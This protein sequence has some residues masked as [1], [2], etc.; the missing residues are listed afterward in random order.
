MKKQAIMI[1]SALV[2]ATL[3]VAGNASAQRQT[4]W[5]KQNPH[6]PF[7]TVRTPVAGYSPTLASPQPETM[8]TLTPDANR[9]IRWQGWL[10]V[11]TF[12][13]S[14][15]NQMQ[16][17]LGR[18]I[19][20]GRFTIAEPGILEAVKN[21]KANNPFFRLNPL[22][23]EEGA[24]FIGTPTL[25]VWTY[26]HNFTDTGLYQLYVSAKG[27][28]EIG[29]GPGPGP[30]PGHGNPI[31]HK[32]IQS[33]NY[34]FGGDGWRP[35]K[36]GLPP[37][38]HPIIIDVEVW[39]GAVARVNARGELEVVG[40]E[41]GVIPL[42]DGTVERI[43]M[44][45]WELAPSLIS[46]PNYNP[47]RATGA[48]FVEPLERAITIRENLNQLQAGDVQQRVRTVTPFQNR[49]VPQSRPRFS[50]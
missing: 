12:S 38:W 5:A 46:N 42:G 24:M 29:D 28:M 48:A 41:A 26:R 23:E 6:P 32:D 43:P 11:D 49:V 25:Y 35:G 50:R 45:D 2:C 47:R 7:P 31:R 33:L 14:V 37:P 21:A 4:T 30:G 44:S 10:D 36:P 34:E 1:A 13:V 40:N 39:R 27:K 15:L 3:F 22:L 20:I 17:Q 9:L 16:K 18:E 8:A 19:P